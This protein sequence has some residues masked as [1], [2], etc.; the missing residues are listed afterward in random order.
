MVFQYSI[1][2]KEENAPVAL[3]ET[4]Q[5]GQQGWSR[6]GSERVRKSEMS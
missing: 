3:T 2:F 6:A 1:G 5:K 4:P